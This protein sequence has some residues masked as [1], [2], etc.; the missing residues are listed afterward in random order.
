MKLFPALPLIPR[1]EADPIGP[2]R[3][4]VVRNDE[5]FAQQ[6]ITQLNIKRVNTFAKHNTQ[7][8]VDAVNEFA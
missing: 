8:A 6:S 4:L 1:S 2:S 5:V 7:N 3:A